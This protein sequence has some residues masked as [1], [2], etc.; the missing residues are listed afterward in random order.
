[1][2]DRRRRAGIYG[3]LLFAILAVFVAG[4]MVG[5]TPNMSARDRGA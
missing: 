3:F 2:R 5:R 1:V 4:L